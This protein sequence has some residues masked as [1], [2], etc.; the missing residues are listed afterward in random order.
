MSY[1]I[2]KGASIVNVV[3]TFSDFSKEGTPFEGPWVTDCS[4]D[5]VRK[6]FN[7]WEPEADE[8]LQVR[9]RNVF[10]HSLV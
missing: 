10:L 4:P 1:G 7:G 9:D 3:A 2:G 8:L 5:D 6:E